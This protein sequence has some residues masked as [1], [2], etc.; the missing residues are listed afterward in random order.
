MR[1][2]NVVVYAADAGSPFHEAARQLRDRGFRGEIPVVVSSQVLLEFFAVITNPQRGQA[3]RSPQEATAEMAKYMRSHRIQTIY[4][5]TDILWR[6][7]ALHAQ[8]RQV[9]RQEIF[10]QY[11]AA[12]MLRARLPY[13]EELLM[14][15]VLRAFIAV[16]LLA[17]LAAADTGLITL[18]SA[19]SVGETGDRLESMLKEKGMMVFARIDHAEGAKKVGATLRPTELLI[20][21]SPKVGTTLMQCGQ[22]VGLDL[23]LK[24]R[25]WEDA[26]GQVW[27]TYHG[28]K[29]LAER[30]GLT[31]CDDVIGR[32][33]QALK[34]FLTAATRP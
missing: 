22:S 17:S 12:T 30:H 7:L 1:D 18:Q 25:I 5:R 10:A 16:L 11:L 15:D 2:A 13:R 23:P 9:T 32:I 14:R 6:V 31:R 28:P 29:Y 19:H 26:R 33:E 27:L 8:H 20:F 4:P 34:N 21:G 24:A 3:P